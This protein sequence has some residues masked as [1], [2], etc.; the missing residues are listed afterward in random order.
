MKLTPAMPAT[1]VEWFEHGCAKERAVIVAWLRRMTTGDSE[2]PH[3]L[4]VLAA[5]AVERGDH[6]SPTM[7]VEPEGSDK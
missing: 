4:L 6:L 3:P 5:G 1:C 2:H 7:V